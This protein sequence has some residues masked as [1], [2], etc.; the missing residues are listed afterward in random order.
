M[1]V[2][3]VFC[4]LWT[5]LMAWRVW[6]ESEAQLKEADVGAP[7]SAF[8]RP[9]GSPVALMSADTREPVRRR[10]GR[11]S[12]VPLD[13][14]RAFQMLFRRETFASVWKWLMKLGIPLR[15]RED[16]RQTVFLAAHRSWSS[17]DPARS[18]PDR[19]LNQITLHLASHY[20]ER[21]LRRHKE[22]RPGRFF[23]GIDKRP[24]PDEQIQA[25]EARMEVRDVLQSLEGNLRAVLVAFDIDGL[26][27]VE[28]AKN[29][30][31]PLSTAYKWRSRALKAFAAEMARREEAERERLENA[32]SPRRS[33]TLS[34]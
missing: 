19:W 17:Y 4:V 16:M 10:V 28:F 8:E 18:G 31:I 6:W 33:A 9:E 15:D 1:S 13:K 11:P 32:P 12:S 5:A 7:D 21:V 30:G 3:L 29:R 25:E 20:W 34:R 22:L 23:D 27:M 24:A 26:S 14:D 2:L